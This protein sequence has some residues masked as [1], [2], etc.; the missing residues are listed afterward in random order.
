MAHP[1]GTDFGTATVLQF[2]LSAKMKSIWKISTQD[3]LRSEG[4]YAHDS[5]AGRHVVRQTKSAT[6]LTDQLNTEETI[7]GI[8]QT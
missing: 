5:S 8:G 7:V 2:C 4:R 3:D 1:Q 6:S